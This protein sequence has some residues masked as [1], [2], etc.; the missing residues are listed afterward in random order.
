VS[1]QERTTL[2]GQALAALSPEQRQVIELSYF[3]G[4]T[5]REI[6]RRLRWPEGTVHTRARLA[7][8]NLRKQVETLGVT[9]EDLLSFV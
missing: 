2:I 1:A 6:A 5:R 8:Q 4:L 3:H 9:P 7:L